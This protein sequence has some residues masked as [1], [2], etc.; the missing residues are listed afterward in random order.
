LSMSFEILVCI[1]KKVGKSTVITFRSS[2]T[3]L[4]IFSLFTG[5]GE[6]ESH[7]N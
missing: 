6:G 1:V 3:Y 4:S 2:P 7:D 5:R